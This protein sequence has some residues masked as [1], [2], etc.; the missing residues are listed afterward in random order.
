MRSLNRDPEPK[1]KNAPAKNKNAA[2]DAAYI[3][4]APKGPRTVSHRRIKE[5]VAEVIRNRA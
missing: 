4:P 1:A 3:M 2:R 5:A